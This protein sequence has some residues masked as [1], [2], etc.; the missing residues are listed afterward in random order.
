MP[1]PSP[2]LGFAEFVWIWNETQN[3]GTP[4]LHKKI[5][6]WLDKRWHMGDKQLLLMAFRASGKSTLVGLFCAW[7]LYG[8]R[9]LR[10]LVLA[11]EQA[12]AIKMVRN[13]KRIIERHPLTQGFKPKGAEQWA[14][15]QFTILRDAELRDPSMLARGIGANLTG[16]RADIVIC[17][18]VEV[19]NTCDTVPK[20]VDLR[21]RLSE[22]DYILV[23]G[24]TQLYVGTPHSFF[25]IYADVARKEAGEDAAFL[26]GFK[27][28]KIPIQKPDGTSNWADRYSQAQIDD[29]KRRHGPNKFN[30][31]MML[32]P[33]SLD[34]GRLS[35][36]R[37]RLYES[38]I[39]YEERNEQA[40]LLLEETELRS[41]SCWWDPAY[42]AV[43]KGDGSVIACVYTSEDGRYWLH[44]VRYLTIDPNAGL[45]EARQQCH[46]VADFIHCYHLPSVTIETNG[47]GKFLPGLLRNVFQKRGLSCAVVEHHSHKPKDQRIIEAYDATL[48]AG[49][50]MAHRSVWD[51][52]FIMEMREW[53]PGN[54]RQAVDDGLDAV[55]GCL[56]S[57]PVRLKRDTSTPLN[58][59][60]WQGLGQGHTADSNF[61]P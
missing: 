8:N 11:A 32:E 21:S 27:R 61:T 16:S 6:R 36:D 41:A 52:P 56:Q 9:N 40:T 59:R 37:L 39:Q 5:S 53:T 45:D 2:Q 22:I 10:I 48:A 18:D 60:K 58:P 34:G 50:L 29:L 30:S 14:A 13:V 23:P 3:L 19:P 7:I 38:D 35:T 47:V 25:T 43:G 33:L 15:E 12:L 51:T 42:G 46:Q 44:A 28:L 54:K 49:N 55:A 26:A 17:D 57:Q 4:Q 24:G 20:R 31:Q 1:A